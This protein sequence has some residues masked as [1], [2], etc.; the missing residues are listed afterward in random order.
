[1]P[2]AAASPG[3]SQD[4]AKYPTINIGYSPKLLAALLA[5]LQR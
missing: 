3:H 5:S 2:L 1:M 4:S